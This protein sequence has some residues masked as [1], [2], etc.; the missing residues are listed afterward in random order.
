[1]KRKINYAVI[2]AIILILAVIGVSAFFAIQ[3][4]KVRVDPTIP[5]FETNISV[6]TKNRATST[7]IGTIVDTT[8][9]SYYA[10]ERTIM[11]MNPGLNYTITVSTLVNN[12]GYWI[13][14]YAIR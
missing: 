6:L 1:M 14:S 3:T 7:S 9:Q 13:T 2:L 5:S 11:S 12:T 8:N 4:T 10:P